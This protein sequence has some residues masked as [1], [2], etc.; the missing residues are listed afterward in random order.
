MRN[1]TQ[2]SHKNETG[3]EILLEFAHHIESI[4]PLNRGYECALKN[5]WRLRCSDTVLTLAASR[6]K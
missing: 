6:G 4:K 2:R 5:G 1:R 3:A